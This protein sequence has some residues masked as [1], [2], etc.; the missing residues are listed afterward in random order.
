MFSKHGFMDPGDPW[1]SPRE[2]AR[3]LE[4]F[5][6]LKYDHKSPLLAEKGN[7]LTVMPT[8][9]TKAMKSFHIQASGGHFK[10][11]FA[12]KGFYQNFVQC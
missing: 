3:F 8:E 9:I 5:I 4:H 11:L 2:Y 12:V 10:T 6:G 7:S 1:R